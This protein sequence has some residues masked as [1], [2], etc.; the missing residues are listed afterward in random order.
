MV[1]HDETAGDDSAAPA[2]AALAAPAPA[3][4]PA[5]A[6]APAAAEA[7]ARGCCPRGLA[8]SCCCGRAPQPCQKGGTEGW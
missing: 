2:D 3:P 1:C 6:A 4:A 7:E 5:P 8:C